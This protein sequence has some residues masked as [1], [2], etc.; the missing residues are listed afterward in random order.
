MGLLLVQCAGW[1]PFSSIDVLIQSFIDLPSYH[2]IL[3]P[4]CT[5]GVDGKK[6]VIWNY[7]YLNSFTELHVSASQSTLA[8]FVTVITIAG[9]LIASSLMA[10]YLNVP[11]WLAVKTTFP[12]ASESTPANNA[13]G[14]GRPVGPSVIVNTAV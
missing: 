3:I 7:H 12:L 2:I 13:P 8:Y 4:S 9:L 14:T 1:R 6:L 5:V 10:L 11:T